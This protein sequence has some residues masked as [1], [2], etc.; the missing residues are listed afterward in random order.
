MG[1]RYLLV[2]LLWSANVLALS[3]DIAFRVLLNDR[4]IGYHHYD[5]EAVAEGLEVA[6]EARYEVR[7]LFFPA[8]TYLHQA[9]E[10]WRDG[11]LAQ[12]GTTTNDNGTDY[13]V[14][15]AGSRISVSRDGEGKSSSLPGDECLRSYAYWH[16]DFTAAS[17]LLNGQT[18]ELAEVS[19]TQAG[20]EPLPWDSTILAR[21][22]VLH[23]PE[24]DIRLWY[25]T[26][27]EWLGLQSSVGKGRLLR[28]Q[29]VGD[30][31]LKQREQWLE[32]L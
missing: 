10:L 14:S 3:P 9:Q 31:A 25:D 11:C 32:N 20:T 24:G 19:F 27:G 7:W 26:D 5:F 21:T 29:R 23:S 16:P 4:E 13:Q 30:V 22:V 6:S 2:L 17:Q 15:V 8:Y 18:G 28:Y 1:V 12:L